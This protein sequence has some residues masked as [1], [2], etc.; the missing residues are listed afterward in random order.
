M[1]CERLSADQLVCKF[2]IDT[3]E[4]DLG[5]TSAN[6]PASVEN[7]EVLVRAVVAFADLELAALSAEGYGF[8]REGS[9][10][11][12]EAVNCMAAPLAAGLLLSL[13]ENTDQFM[14]AEF[15]RGLGDGDFGN[16]SKDVWTMMGYALGSKFRLENAIK[17]LAGAGEMCCPDIAVEEGNY[18]EAVVLASRLSGLEEEMVVAR[19]DRA[20]TLA[21]G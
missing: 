16:R 14:R 15:L 3:I 7:Q 2:V 20:F 18:K 5:P 19:I 9:P 8:E 21:R 6:L 11:V 12:V 17:A 4:A 10:R 13:A 1:S